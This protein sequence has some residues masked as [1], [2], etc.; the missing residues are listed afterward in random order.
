MHPSLRQLEYLVAIADHGG[1]HRAAEAC[2]VT[3][4]GLSA[5]IKQ[6]ED[7]L[8]VRLMERDRRRLLFTPAGKAIVGR[9][10]AILAATDELVETARVFT[11]PLAGVLRL[12]V[13]PTVAPYWLPATLPR[14]RERFPELKL[15]LLEDTTERLLDALRAGDLDLLLLALEADLGDV[16]TLALEQDPF[17]VTLPADHPLARRKRLGE[18]DLEGETV[19]LLQ[20][21][22]CLRDQALAVCG[23]AGMT[24]VGDFRATSLGTLVQMVAT[25]A[26]ITL[27]PESAVEVEL[28]GSPELVTRPFRKPVPHRTIGLAWRSTSPRGEEFELLGDE[29]RRPPPD[30]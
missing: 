10:R 18:S 16:V 26:G 28:R 27:L 4:P 21:G 20:D 29:M 15:R 30:R 1:F 23:A 3:Q 7:V 24:E 11:R 9:A 25:G 13:I 22:H 19:L 6:L 17:V 14:V 2:H 8:D 12:G 5:Q